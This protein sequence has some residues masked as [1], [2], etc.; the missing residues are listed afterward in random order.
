MVS[1]G[2]KSTERDMETKNKDVHLSGEEIKETKGS[3]ADTQEEGDD[4]EKNSHP[5]KKEHKKRK[6]KKQS[7]EAERLKIKL[8]E[9]NDKYL[10]LYSEFDNYRRRTS[11]EKLEMA[12][13]AAESLIV[14][15]LPVLDDFERAIKSAEESTDCDAV[16]DGMTL[17]YNK[18][19]GILQKKG[20]ASIDAIGKDFDT[21]FHEA[22]SYLP[23]PSKD[24]KGK[25]IEQVEKGYTLQ[26]KVIRYS[27]VVI[28][29]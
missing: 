3:A 17:I 18:F 25:V 15:L 26:E 1:K 7:A 22:I 11:R 5:G 28:G 21:D 8:S 24:K 16:K 27:K 9:A 2:N 23:A 29:Q 4:A 6:G 20:L 12:K 10:R 13:T 19:N 14:E